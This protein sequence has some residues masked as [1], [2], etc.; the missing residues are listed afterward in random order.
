MK[1]TIESA[2][3]HC[4]YLDKFNAVDDGWSQVAEWLREL[5]RMK[6]QKAAA[7]SLG[8]TVIASET[9]L[10]DGSTASVHRV[11][12]ARQFL[13]TLGEDVE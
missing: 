13:R 12:L 10:G 3:E 11:G 7:V 6:P 9:S 2:I 5:K 4:E 1:L 8:R